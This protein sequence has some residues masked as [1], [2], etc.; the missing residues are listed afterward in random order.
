MKDRFPVQP[1][2]RGEHPHFKW[3]ETDYIVAATPLRGGAV[4]VAIPLPPEFAQTAKQIQ[5]S[6]ENYRSRSE[7]RIH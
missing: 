6:Q 2:L 5:E 7:K 3:G 4:L 1:A